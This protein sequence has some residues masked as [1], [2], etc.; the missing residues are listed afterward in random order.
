M[1]R[2]VRPFAL[3]LVGLAMVAAA[4]A[5]GEET[6]SDEAQV[7]ATDQAPMTKG[8]L[9]SILA[10]NP[11]ATQLDQL[12][13]LLPK[14][15]LLNLT[16]KHGRLFQGEN[17]HLVEQVVSQSSSPGAPRAILWDERSGFASS[18]NGGVDGQTEP[19]R[20][21][22]IE[23]DTDKKEFRFT[24]LE[25]NGTGAPQFKTEADIP[26]DA[27]KC[28]HCHGDKLRPIFSMYPDWPS[29]YGSDNDE[30]TETSKA[31]EAREFS[32]FRAF[33][34]DV[35]TKRLP[36]YLPLFDGANV[37]SHLRG[38]DIYPSYPY[39][40]DTNTNIEAVS[41]AFAFRPALR[42]GILM[43]RL[44][45]QATAQRIQSH[46]NFGKFG[47]FFLHD[48][49]ECRWS[50]PTSLQTT[51]WLDAVQSVI[52]AAPRTV[53]GGRTLHYRDLLQIFGLRVNDVDLRYS[54][55][56]TGFANEDASN[57]V[58]EVGYIDN[59]YWNSYFDGSTTI[60]ELLSKH[61]Y[62]TLSQ[63]PE[64]KDLAGTITDPD[65]LV[66]KYSRRAERF[67]FDKNYFEEMD[68]KGIWIPI[69]YPEA[70]LNEV[71]H[72]EGYPDRFAN[73]HRALCTKLEDHLK[74]GPGTS[75]GSTPPVDPGAATACPESCVASAFCKDHPNAASAIKVD[76]LPCMVSGAAGCQPC[77]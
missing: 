61:L 48:L 36:R 31:V 32:D 13:A 20:L 57:K 6:N 35:Q 1:R 27:R 56:H 64:L 77:R 73:Q 12:P 63:T 71:H 47:A 43:N 14:E 18:Y 30:L 55:N 28:S 9:E 38:T 3:G 17:G 49:L 67:K 41:R 60:D 15:F 51:G 34:N 8:R 21:D 70:K 44:Q 69:P 75:G 22:I 2:G 11:Q 24:G 33:K 46:P 76:G 59:Q 65:G 25:F 29:F 5:Q 19:N 58:M 23:F 4:C 50:T 52:G 68:R 62:D 39:R 74:S 37:K 10:A 16:L 66:V 40:P 42:F 7:I 54:I 45:A 53:A 26:E 72:R